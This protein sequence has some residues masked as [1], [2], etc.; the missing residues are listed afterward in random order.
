MHGNI[1]QGDVKVGFWNA[2]AFDMVGEGAG[3][4][5]L[6][7]LLAE[8]RESEPDV[9][10]VFECI[11]AFDRFRVRE[12]GL[13]LRGHNNDDDSVIQATDPP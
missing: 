5:K 10:F 3:A 11:G 1:S 9:F 8:L 4:E 13:S 7:W 2:R 12:Y 6:R